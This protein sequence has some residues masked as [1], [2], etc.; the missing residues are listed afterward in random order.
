VIDGELQDE[1]EFDDQKSISPKGFP[2]MKVKFGLFYDDEI[3]HVKASKTADL[4]LTNLKRLSSLEEEWQALHDP[5]PEA[6][7]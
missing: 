6:K 5:R 3:F 7:Y 2:N 4:D 1:F